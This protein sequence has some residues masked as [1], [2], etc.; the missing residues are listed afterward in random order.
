VTKIAGTS[1]YEHAAE[2]QRQRRLVGHPAVEKLQ[3][4]GHGH[5]HDRHHRKVDGAADDHDTHADRQDPEDRDAADDRDQVADGEETIQ[6]E[7]A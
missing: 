4:P 3:V 6:E 5:G 1:A 7:R 2:H